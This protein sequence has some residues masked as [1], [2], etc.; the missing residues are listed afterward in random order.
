[1]ESHLSTECPEEYISCKFK[2]F[3]C[4]TAVRRREKESHFSDDTL[5]LR[6]SMETQIALFQSLGTLFQSATY[7]R[8]DVAS[9]PLSFRPWLQNTPTCYPRPPWVVKLEGF[10]EK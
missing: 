3:G 7:T 4:G 5:H 8:P 10:E 6:K 1:M 2:M 9:L